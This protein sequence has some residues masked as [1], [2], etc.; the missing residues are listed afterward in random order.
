MTRRNICLVALA[1]GALSFYG[2]VYADMP[3]M[4]PAVKVDARITN[5]A[6]FPGITLIA[7]D[8][9]LSW[10][11]YYYVVNPGTRLYVYGGPAAGGHKLKIIAVTGEFL[12]SSQSAALRARL[13]GF[14]GAKVRSNSSHGFDDDRPDSFGLTDNKPGFYAADDEVAFENESAKDMRD[15]LVSIEREYRIAGFMDRNLKLYLAKETRRFSGWAPAATRTFPNP[16]P[17]LPAGPQPR[18]WVYAR[19]HDAAAAGDIAGVSGFLA[20]GAAVDS[21]DKD[22]H[23]PLR[24]A[25][26]DG[27]TAMADYLAS[28]GADVN[29]GREAPLLAAVRGGFLETSEFLLGRGARL[30]VKDERGDTLLLWAAKSDNYELVRLIAEGFIAKGMGLDSPDR[31]GNTPLRRAAERGRT[32]MVK[33]LVAK[34]AKVNSGRKSPLFAAVR[35]GNLEMAKYLLGHGART[36]LKDIEGRTPLVWAVDLDN[37]K[38]VKILVESGADVNAPSALAGYTLLDWAKTDRMRGL[39]RGYGARPG[40]SGAQKKRGTQR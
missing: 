16:F 37:E 20:E 36:D 8:S 5:Q 13:D 6:E 32:A 27:Q 1:A 21:P 18:K 33:Y 17:G 14:K 12:N 25:A 10:K 39:L 35:G 23:T 30:N 31:D 15:P 38:L 40:K 3:P 22:G 11:T 24:W 4:P 28:R 2:R 26:E 9:C 29:C 34:G 7:R 19:I